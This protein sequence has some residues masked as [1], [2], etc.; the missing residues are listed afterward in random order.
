MPRSGAQ[1]NRAAHQLA[2]RPDD[3]QHL[4]VVLDDATRQILSAQLEPCE[5]THTVM[6]AL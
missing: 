3:Y 2:L 6:T 1:R 4:I 5:S